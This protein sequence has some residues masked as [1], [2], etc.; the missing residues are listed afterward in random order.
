M[1]TML[2]HLLQ[3]AAYTSSAE[4]SFNTSYSPNPVYY[5]PTSPPYYPSPHGTG[6]GEWQQAYA[7]AV[8]FVKQLM[9]LEK[10]N[11]TTG[12]GWTLGPC[13]GNTGSVPRLNFRGF[14]LQDSPLGVRFADYVSVFPPL[15]QAGRTWNRGLIR[16]H[17]QAMGE[18]FRGKG[19]NVLL[20]PVA[21]PLGTFAEGGR[22]WEGFANDP[23]LC[24]QAIAESVV[25]IQSTGAIACAKHFLMNE[26]EHF[27]QAP[28]SN[29]F[30]THLTTAQSLSSNVDDRV[31]HELY[32]WPFADA[33]RAGVGS[34]MCSYNQLN[35]S[36]ACQNSALL[37]GLLKDEMGFQGFVVSDWGAVHSGVATYLAGTDMLM[38]GDG[39]AFSDG[40]SWFGKELTISVLNGTIPE[41]LLDD[42]V[43]RIMAAHFKLGQQQNYPEPNFSSFVPNQQYGYLYENDY[44]LL[45]QYVDVR[46]SHAAVAQQVNQ[47]SI[48]LLK[49]NNTLPLRNVSWL[50]IIGQ[51]AGSAAYGPNGC[52]DRGCDNGTLGIGW[53]SGTANYPYLIT[54]LEAIGARARSEGSLVYDILDN[55]AY[56]QITD[57]AS[58]PRS[59]SLVFLTS[60]S[61]EGYI[62]VDG[63]EGD[64]NNLTAWHAGDQLVKTVALASSNVVVI[65]N[66]VGPLILESWINNPN[67]TAVVWAGLPGQEAGNTLAGMLYGDFNPSGKL[68]YTIAKNA[69][70]YGQSLMYEPNAPIPQYN[71]T[72]SNIDYRHFDQQNIQPRFEFG[73]GMS[74]T[75]FSITPGNVTTISTAPYAK[76]QAGPVAPSI[77]S[78]NTTPEQALFP[79]GFTKVTNWN[80]PNIDNTSEA[81]PGMAYPY[82]TN[83]SFKSP[84]GGGPGGNPSLWDVLIRVT[85]TVTNTGSTAGAEVAQLYVSFPQSMEYPTPPNQL[86]GFS[87][88]YLNPSGTQ[89]VSFDVTRRDLSVW[90]TSAQNWVF[91]EGVYSFNVGNSSRSLMRVGGVSLR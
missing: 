72:T 85:A 62:S 55:Y 28:E 16:S 39:N 43:I 40:M 79:A 83:T 68:T 32:A 18:E 20:G 5:S 73:Y 54:P 84:A 22:N 33:V 88:V 89:Q 11:I 53:G 13:V 76:R 4:V 3:L 36:Y 34:I 49:N 69:S 44:T 58:V 75:S 31:L 61:G 81:K 67:V 46:S 15:S 70:D 87:K 21:G 74:Y 41:S 86:R 37:N 2:L 57:L 23:Y 19:A 77:P 90:N 25:G 64:R 71:F 26:Q 63:N 91:L 48:V 9:L 65:V 82:P 78:T 45:N 6:E 29:G 42:K 27:R 1:G 7:Q 10:V 56:D 30:K 35:N 38:P 50:N 59:T 60:D 80:Y 66:S 47:E 17:G 24:G 52:S 14:C 12:T 8:D 51:G